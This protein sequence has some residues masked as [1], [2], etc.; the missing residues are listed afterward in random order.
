MDEAFPEM[1]RK[2]KTQ[3][4]V[5]RESKNSAYSQLRSLRKSIL[6]EDD[7]RRALNAEKT[8][9]RAKLELLRNDIISFRRS[10][11][12]VPS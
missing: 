7:K 5:M 12:V 2:V 9:L 10:L 6:D 4:D 3:F 11:A 1:I 8:L